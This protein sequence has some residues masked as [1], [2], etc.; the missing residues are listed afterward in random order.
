MV[1]SVLLA[2]E[3]L[4]FG[5]SVGS[6]IEAQGPRSGVTDG[7]TIA[8]SAS[9]ALIYYAYL[10]MLRTPSYNLV[11][12]VGITLFCFGV[13]R[14]SRIGTQGSGRTGPRLQLLTSAAVIAVA[15]FVAAHGKPSTPVLLGAASLPLLRR[16]LGD[17]QLR[18][19]LIAIIS[20]G[21]G[22]VGGAWVSPFWPADAGRVLLRVIEL[23]T[24]SDGHGLGRAVF[25][26][27]LA[28]ADLLRGALL[29]QPHWL[30]GPVLVLL[31]IHL[32]RL[33]RRLDRW[34]GW[35]G[36][37]PAS[38]ALFVIG[39]IAVL[40]PDRIITWVHAGGLGA[41]SNA[42]M[43]G[44]LSWPADGYVAAF[45]GTVRLA[46]WMLGAPLA[47]SVL[48][49]VGRRL[50]L[51]TAALLLAVLATLS[52]GLAGALGLPGAGS[53]VAGIEGVLAVWLFERAAHDH[54]PVWTR[55]SGA[56]RRRSLSTRSAT[57]VLLF[58]AIAAYGFGHDTGPTNAMPAAG[59]LAV[60]AIMFILVTSPR[61]R[62]GALVT[63]S[64]LA[65][66]VTAAGISQA[67]AN[68]YRSTP[69]SENTVPVAFG[70]NDSLLLLDPE[71]A[72]FLTELR[73]AA[74]DGG[75]EPDVRLYGLH[76]GWS[77]TIPYFLGAEVPPSILPGLGFHRNGLARL[78]FDLARGDYEGWDAAWLLLPDFSLTPDDG[79]E[80]YELAAVREAIRLFTEEVGTSWPDD[81][82]LV[83]T[84]PRDAPRSPTTRITLW[85]P[86]R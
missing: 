79:I 42:V 23:P 35:L 77:S 9:A 2:R 25:L 43:P 34:E 75:W 80:A 53:V 81:Y 58:G 51:S 18:R 19:V 52:F 85:K 11:N 33:Q 60:A 86:S 36:A 26:L 28:P 84:A 39:V 59:G 10:P 32:V 78:R 72:R 17:Q 6:V 68:P 1:A 62:S 7:I 57:L 61:Q 15:A 55:V 37:L 64:L 13:V 31:G 20:I 21:L 4:L 47:A 63:L 56:S 45:G 66:S 41:V 16:S 46:G 5:R 38:L 22:L 12:L 50:I 76:V 65:V 48:R 67:W 29:S 8:A 3:L 83:W 82:T 30:V 69:I 54:R 73:D 24:V 27:A 71:L 14:T 49:S 74:T 70:A 44:R 40:A